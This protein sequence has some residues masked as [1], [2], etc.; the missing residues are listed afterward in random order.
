M[1]LS[2]PLSE[3]AKKLLELDALTV[4]A[5]SDVASKVACNAAIAA[6][7]RGETHYT[8]R[9]GILPLRKKVAEM[10]NSRY[11]LDADPNTIVITCGDTEARFVSVHCLLGSGDSL[12]CLENAS[13]LE[14]ALTIRDARLVKP[15]EGLESV[16]ALY[17]TS[18]TSEAKREH[19]VQQAKENNWWIIF[20]VVND[21]NYHPARDAALKDKV[22][23]IG[24]LGKAHGLESWRVGFLQAPKGEAPEL[25][26][27]KQALTICTTSLSQYAAL[28]VMEAS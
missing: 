1:T 5:S 7:E 28:A 6:L 22:I 16:K 25:R 14:P 17:L 18:D 20:E 13:L 2:I 26:T 4:S 10:V 12:L 27:F 9:P 19:Y 24:A 11:D 8:D 15:G 3:R 21:E 23:T